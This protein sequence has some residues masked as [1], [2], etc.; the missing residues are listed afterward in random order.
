MIRFFHDK[1]QL[2]FFKYRLGSMLVAA[3]NQ[4]HTCK[5]LLQATA[6]GARTTG[7]CFVGFHVGFQLSGYGG[8]HHG[9]GTVGFHVGFHVGFQLSGYEGGH[10]GKGTMGVFVS[11]FQN[12]GSMLGAMFASMLGSSCQGTGEVTMGKIAVGFHVSFFVGVQLSG[13]GLGAPGGPSPVGSKSSSPCVSLS[14]NVEPNL[15]PGKCPRGFCA[16]RPRLELPLLG[17]S[18]RASVSRWV[19]VESNLERVKC[20]RGFGARRFW[21]EVLPTGRLQ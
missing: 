18:S 5:A 1:V 8:G 19:N 21:P 7:F 10:H 4:S 14:V 16:R 13:Y 6:H 11:S 3:A 12:M 9:K 2:I 17:R 15:G 20:P